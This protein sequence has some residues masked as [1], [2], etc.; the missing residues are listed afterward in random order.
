MQAFHIVKNG[1]PEKAFELRDIS[2]PAVE[3]NEVIVE[4]EAFGINF[5]D[6]M[7]RLGLY[8]DCPP[9]PAVIGYEAVGRIKQKSPDV[10]HVDIGDRVVAFTRFGGYSQGVKTRGDAVVR[11]SDDYPAGKALALAT[12]YCT[13]Y[14]A[15]HVATNVMPGDKVL[16]Q[17]AAGGV[18]TALIQLCKLQ[19]CTIYGT[20]GSD[21]KLDH[22]R[23]LGVDHPINYRSQ[24]F[25]K[26]ISE[27][28]DMVFDSIGGETF[29]KGY[30]LLDKGGRMVAYGAAS[31]TDASNI[32]SKLKFGIDFG[33]YHPAQFI[34]ESRSLIGVNML[35]IA[36]YK[37]HII[38][39]CLQKVVELA[40]KG[41]LDPHVGGMYPTSDLAKVHQMV[42]DR[43]TMGKIGIYWE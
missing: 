4:V 21:Y 22:L 13:A 3:E 9:L 40:L 11:I 29:K 23:T 41:D 25:S 1:K 31:Q 26:A 15:A 18:G 6:V 2:I 39:H 20:A 38:Q 34:M 32:F 43:K 27:P 5:A 17:A 12:Q 8:R 37:P 24:D 7:A 36:D 14:Y 42:E 28:L 10:S 35:R 19:N 16:I 30:K 33:I